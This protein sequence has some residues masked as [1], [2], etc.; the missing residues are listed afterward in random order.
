MLA[1]PLVVD[2]GVGSMGRSVS[3]RRFDWCAASSS[4]V[5]AANSLATHSFTAQTIWEHSTEAQPARESELSVR[6][7][8]VENGGL[9][10]QVDQ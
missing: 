6:L 4:G 3:G 7:F 8:R 1:D 9:A 2:R 5:R 10:T